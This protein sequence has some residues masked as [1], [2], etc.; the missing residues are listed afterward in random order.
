MIATKVVDWA[1][2]GKVMVAGLASGVVKPDILIISGYQ[3]S[4]TS[5]QAR[6]RYDLWTTLNERRAPP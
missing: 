4:P 3:E 2:L 6:I 5:R 1:T